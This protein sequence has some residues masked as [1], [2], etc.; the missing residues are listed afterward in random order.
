MACFHEPSSIM[1]CNAA[2]ICLASVDWPD[3]TAIAYERSPNVSP[4]TLRYPPP[5]VGCEARRYGVICRDGVRLPDHQCRFALRIRVAFAHGHIFR[6]I[7]H[8]VGGYSSFGHAYRP[9]GKII[10]SGDGSRTVGTYQQ[11]R[12]HSQI[13]SCKLN[14][15]IL[16][17]ISGESIDHHVHGAVF[18]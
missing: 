12:M 10:G 18:K 7:S 16:N 5:L 9:S 8:A 15:T 3:L 1:D 17:V 2:S 14:L 13:R 4:T 6:K 11:C